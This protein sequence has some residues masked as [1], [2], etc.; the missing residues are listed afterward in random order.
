MGAAI[1]RL[2]GGSVVIGAVIGATA[3][4][5]VTMVIYRAMTGAASGV[6]NSATMPGYRGNEAAGYSH[7]EALEAKGDIAGALAAWEDVIR[8]GPDA[9]AARMHAADLY[10]RK[11]NNTQRA[12]ELFRAI[13]THASAPAEVQRYASQRLVDLYLGPLND[14]GRAL[15]ELRK[16]AD[17]WPG[18][19]EADGAKRAIADIKQQTTRRREDEKTR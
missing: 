19:P 17:R 8:G 9:V 13:Q 11:G 16:I 12:A 4:P 5:L 14:A 1:A 2:T 18:T 10:A 15:V 6:I 7:I 3:M